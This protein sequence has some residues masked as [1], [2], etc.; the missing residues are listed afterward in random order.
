MRCVGGEKFGRGTRRGHMR[1]LCLLLTL[2]TTLV[3]C[4]SAR[5][6]TY[7]VY[8]CRL[9]DGS[10]APARG[11]VPFANAS[12]LGPVGTAANECGGGGGLIASLPPVA[13]AGMDAG[14]RF[15]SP[16]GTTIEGFEIFRVVRPMT[17]AP[18]P[19]GGYVASLGAWPPADLA[20]DVDERCLGGVPSS[21]PCDKGLGISGSP[22]D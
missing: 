14:W 10:P 6:G 7:E 5:A 21:P 1:A 2:L 22:F 15:A 12:E 18:G 19:V 20:N 17:G 16:P 4:A 8:S 11:W 9:P 3:A 13:L